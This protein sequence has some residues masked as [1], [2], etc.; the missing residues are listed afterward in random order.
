MQ[1]LLPE[2]ASSYQIVEFDIPAK[3]FLDVGSYSALGNVKINAL[4]I[5]QKDG[6]LYGHV[7]DNDNGGARCLAAVSVDSYTCLCQ[8]V[9]FAY[10]GVF[11]EGGQFWYSSGGPTR[12]VGQNVFVT[13]TSQLHQLSGSDGS[14]TCLYTAFNLSLFPDFDITSWQLTPDVLSNHYGMSYYGGFQWATRW[15]D[16]NADGYITKWN[17]FGRDGV[18]DFVNYILDGTEYL[19]GLTAHDAAMLIIPIGTP[20]QETVNIS[21]LTYAFAPPSIDWEDVS[22]QELGAFGAGYRFGLDEE[23]KVYFAS[24]KGAGVFEVD[25]ISFQAA[26]LLCDF[27]NSHLCDNKAVTLRFI[28]RT[29]EALK[30]D[31]FSCDQSPDPFYVDADPSDWTNETCTNECSA[32][33]S[34]G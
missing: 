28:S 12:Q 20:G 33:Y 34:Y 13:T 19:L 24:N 4:G 23:N 7:Q 15:T 2:G 31:G 30:N 32:G 17:P 18:H 8:M 29:P 11:S 26:V 21:T 27:V 3:T 22:P 16:V 10:A 6:A 9:D 25:S 14:S 1:V 5:N